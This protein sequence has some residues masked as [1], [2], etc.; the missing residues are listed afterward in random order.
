MHPSRA[1]N[2]PG[3]QPHVTTSATLNPAGSGGGWHVQQH[4]PSRSR[5]HHRRPAQQKHA[6]PIVGL[7]G[8]G[9]THDGGRR[10]TAAISPALMPSS[11][12]AG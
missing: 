9:F 2:T 5:D 1:R 6:L 7:W 10:V 3:I 11:A 8:N 12:G 4:H